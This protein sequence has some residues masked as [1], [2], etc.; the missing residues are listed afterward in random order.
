[1]FFIA[2]AFFFWAKVSVIALEPS[3]FTPRGKIY[4]V[5]KPVNFTDM[6]FSLNM[7]KVYDEKLR[8]GFTKNDLN[9]E[10]KSS[11]KSKAKQKVNANWYKDPQYWENNYFLSL[12]Y[13]KFNMDF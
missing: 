3:Y 1:M 5:I 10:Q 13:P 12:P 7:D 9:I 8:K 11:K 4:F 6:Y 2:L